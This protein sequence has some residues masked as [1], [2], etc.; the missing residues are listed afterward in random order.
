MIRCLVSLGANVN[1]TDLHNKNAL[2]DGARFGQLSSVR[3]LI[4]LGC[5]F[6]LKDDQQETPF[7]TAMSTG[8]LEVAHFL[9]NIERR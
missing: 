6:T 9:R 3:L 4:S 5:D 7:L 2:H 1:S 8:T